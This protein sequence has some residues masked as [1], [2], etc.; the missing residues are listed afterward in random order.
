VAYADNNEVAGIMTL[1]ECFAVYANGYYGVIN[2]MYVKP[3]FR[4]HGIGGLLVKS[5]KK[6]G[7]ECSWRR[8]DVTAPESERWI[9]TQQF[10]EKQG[11]VFTGP[12]LNI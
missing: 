6:W 1:V 11:F 5:A 2:E 3:Q 8:I 4:S 12:K 10:Y 7:I 9:R